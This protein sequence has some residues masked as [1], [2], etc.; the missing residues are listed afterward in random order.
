M[1]YPPILVAG[2]LA[3]GIAA[4]APLH[5]VGQDQFCVTNGVL[6]TRPNGVLA[7]DSASSRAVLRRSAG[8]SAEIRFRYLGPSVDSKPLASGEMRRQIGIKLRARDTCNLLYVMWHIEPEDRIAVS[9]KSNPGKHTHAE[10]HGGGYTNIAPTF[11]ASVPRVLRGEAHT[12][13]A[14]LEDG[15]VRVFADGRLVWS[16]HIGE[17]MEQIDGPIGFRTDNGRFEFDYLA[18]PLEPGN[19]QRA[20]DQSLYHC[21]VG[22]GD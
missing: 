6:S 22:P 3:F 4:A 8:Q 21:A 7:V 20:A 9:V 19:A 13:R 15:D 17:R 10:C 16:G 18:P 2:V 12:L 11:K 14:L 1:G 5:P